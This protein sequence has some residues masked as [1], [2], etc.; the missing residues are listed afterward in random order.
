MSLGALKRYGG[1]VGRVCGAACLGGVLAAAAEYA[2]GALSG[3]GAFWGQ[4][5]FLYQ[6]IFGAEA[7]WAAVVGG[8]VFAAGG[9]VYYVAN[10]RKG[11]VRLE[12]PP[13]LTAVVAVTGAAFFYF[14]TTCDFPALI[15]MPTAVT[16]GIFVLGVAA[17]FVGA[18]AVYGALTELRR[19][20]GAGG[21]LPA[22]F[23]RVLALGLLGPFVLAEGWA[24][25]RARVPS[26]RRPD[27]YLVVMDAFRADRLSYYDAPRYLAPT[28]EMFGVD[29]VV[30]RE[31]YTVSSWTKPAVASAFTATYP[32]THGVN[33][34]FLP[35][36]KEAATLAE[37]LRKGGYRTISV[38]AN[39]NV[40][41]PARTVD[42]FDIADD[43]SHGPLF[44]AAG[45]PV[46][47]MRPFVAF[48]GLRP[49]LGPL[50]IRS[51]DGLNVTARLKFWT[52]FAG[53]RPTF[54]YVHY[55]EPHIPNWPR[56][57]YAFEYRPYLA[58]V[59]PSRLAR[60][61]SGPFFWHEVLKDPTFVPE[62]DANELALARALYD[63]D[64][65][66]MDVVI[67]ALLEDVI[68]RSDRG[69]G[70]VIVI[71][72][73]H[74]EEF[75]E[76]GRWLHGAGL[77]H[78]VARVPLMIKA[79]GCRPGVV[80]GPVDLVDLPRTLASFAGLEPPPA[81]EGLDLTPAIMSGAELPRRKLLLEGIHTILP[82]S[83]GEETGAS[84]KLYGLVDGDYYYLKDENA[85]VEYL[86][87][88]RRDRWQKDNLAADA[89]FGGVLAEARA[90]TARL[91]A[92]AAAKAF[93]QEEM[94]L[95][96]ATERQL[97]TLGY[98][99]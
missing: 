57:E 8:V 39:P 99:K 69:A 73:D 54:Y 25:W 97:K 38:S 94:R 13:L 17:W 61:A 41:R 11:P 21:A 89:E 27:I 26:P 98:L 3:A 35:I 76:H 88:R 18:G 7:L 67:E 50:F 71:T 77:H 48:E 12:S 36:P 68:G 14:L 65:R 81:W 75:L 1:F 87:D 70:A 15:A 9:T 79:P 63:A 52:G 91:R 51:L 72:A 53:E 19:R 58:R 78:E 32:G 93:R 90:A 44:N 74:G 66:R 10:V 59:D 82:P 2:F 60:I 34:S 5:R 4:P 40:T 62:F 95:T 22:Y 23:L 42:G 45:P 55:M 31:A 56:P 30:F 85:D 16:A 92:R 84:L 96:P 29:A 47:C 83:A 86:Y 24:L 6:L 46:S 43:T 28:L 20:I 49:L 80:E 37:V 33:A 64:I